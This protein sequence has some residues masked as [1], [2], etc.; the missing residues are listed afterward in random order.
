MG[1]KARIGRR[2]EA[3]LD[4]NAVFAEH[5][6]WLGRVVAVRVGERQA[7]EEVL[8]EVALAATKSGAAVEP[9]RLSAWLYRVAIRTTLLYRRRCG[10]QRKLIDRVARRSAESDEAGPLDWLVAAE[11]RELVR[12][13]LARLGAK[14]REILWLRYGENWPCRQVAERMGASVAAVEARLH[15]ARQRL[16][17]EL[18]DA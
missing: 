2:S 15:R 12:A 4:W 13:A 10:R 8:Q 7:V 9:G 11:R 17:A 3:P 6:G 14:D 1:G 5:G 18:G 16:R